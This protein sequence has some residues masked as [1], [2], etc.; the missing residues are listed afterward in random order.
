MDIA[1]TNVT[2][3]IPTNVMSTALINYHSKKVN[4]YFYFY[5]KYVLHNF[6]LAIIL[7]LMTIIICYHYVRHRSKLKNIL[8]CCQEKIENY[9]FYKV[10]VK[11]HT[12]YYFDDII[13]LE[14]FDID[15]ILIVKIL[16]WRYFDL[17][18][19]I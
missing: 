9:E 11:S 10:L 16:T 8:Q 13:R 3:A 17:W 18:H 19:L 15:N 4:F 5:V 12:R 6:L 14:D 7:L 1:S 2:N